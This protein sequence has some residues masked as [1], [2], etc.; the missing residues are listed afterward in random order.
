MN[1]MSLL[2]NKRVI[3]KWEKK[4]QK[5]QQHCVQILHISLHDFP[6]IFF[7]SNEIRKQ[8]SLKLKRCKQQKTASPAFWLSQLEPSHGC[9]VASGGNASLP[10]KQST[11]NSCIYGDSERHKPHPMQLLL[12]VH[13]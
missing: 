9:A 4:K 6:L 2:E 12:P 3:K 1:C 5:H 10:V 7:N 11:I 8:T 13:T